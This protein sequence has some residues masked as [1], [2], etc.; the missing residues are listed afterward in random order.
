MARATCRRRV[1]PSGCHAARCKRSAPWQPSSMAWP[2]QADSM[3]GGAGAIRRQAARRRQGPLLRTQCAWREMGCLRRATPRPMQPHQLD[4]PKHFSSSY[5]HAMRR[6]WIREILVPRPSPRQG[7]PLRRALAVLL[8][9][10]SAS[11]SL[12]LLRQRAP[13]PRFLDVPSFRVTP[14]CPWDFGLRRPS[15]HFSGP[16]LWACRPPRCYCAVFSPLGTPFFQCPQL[17][18]LGWGRHVEMV[19]TLR[20]GRRRPRAAFATRYRS[21]TQACN[22]HPSSSK[23]AL[24][25]GSS[26][27]MAPNI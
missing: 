25:Q 26:G 27:C 16:P 9:S 1:S 11:P 24:K 14:C 7:A 23:F 22:I 20:A 5:V 6:F 12:W 19:A 21:G 2:V 17:P 18:I 4:A 8:S 3:V 15:G 10:L 13:C